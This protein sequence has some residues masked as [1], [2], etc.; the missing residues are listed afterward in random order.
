MRRVMPFLQEPEED[1]LPCHAE[2]V[3]IR[4]AAGWSRARLG[5]YIGGA[6]R[7]IANWELPSEPTPIT[8]YRVLYQQALQHLEQ[9]ALNRALE[10]AYDQHAAFLADQGQK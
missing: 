3:R 4:E 8:I 1:E 9:I 2:R 6:P 10:V 5:R 7:N